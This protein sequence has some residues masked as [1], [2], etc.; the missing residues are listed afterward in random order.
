MMGL[1]Q[2]IE[3]SGFSQWVKQSGSLWAFPG[4]LLLHTY[5]MAILV[6]VI[7]GIDL[8]IL[9]LM[10]AVPVAPLRKLMPLV[11]AAFWVNAITGTMLLAADATS[12]M[13]NPDFGIKMAFIVLAVIT[14]RVIQKRVFG[15]PDLDRKPFSS[16]AK[17]LATASLVCWLGAI[18]AGRLLAY[19]GNP[20]GL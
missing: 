7:A 14:Q 3:S 8:R 19:V 9:G 2:S 12:K 18:T 20:G 17:M 16:N 4:I 5:G 10:P 6:G 1:L 15:D 11:W 13:R